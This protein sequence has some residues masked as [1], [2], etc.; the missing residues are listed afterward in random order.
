MANAALKELALAALFWTALIGAASAQTIFLST[1]LRPIEEA[2]KVREVILKD[3]A[4]EVSFVP[5][6]TGLFLTRIK[7]EAETGKHTIGVVGALHGDLPPVVK[8]MDSVE[9]VMARLR[10][11][12]FISTFADLGKLGTKH[13][14]YVPWMQA[15]YIMAANKKALEHLPKG[16]DLNTLTFAQL[17]TWAK[18]I[19]GG[20]KRRLGFPAGPKG[21]MHRFFQG[22]LYPSYTG[23]VVRTFKSAAAQAMWNDF[24]ELWQYV[25]PRSTSYNFMQEPLLAGEVWIAFDHTARLLDAL[26]QKPDDFVAFPG[27]AGDA[28]R[29]FMPVVAGLAIPKGAPD[30]A[31][32]AALIDYMTRPAVQMLMLRETGFYPV[33][34]AELPA[35]LPAGIKIAAAAISA[36]AGAADT[37]PSLLP[38]GLGDKG[39]Q[40]NKIYLDTFQRIVLRGQDV[41]KTLDAEA[42]KLARI[43]EQSGAPCWKPDAPSD[44]PCPVE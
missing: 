14:V 12:K 15:T 35:E 11:R 29:G 2:Q 5:E 3:F 4:G 13:Q 38:V 18:N 19:V 21:L 9:D 25:T 33:V 43:M 37:L 36:Q 42:R 27:P 7:A 24:K 31:A 32:A 39:G 16:A 28:G 17:K 41:R 30:R 1:Q 34:D 40:F 23:G 44:G 10:G 20:G 22:Y 26:R 6:D 8:A